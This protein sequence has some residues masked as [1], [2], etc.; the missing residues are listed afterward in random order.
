MN[1]HVFVVLSIFIPASGFERVLNQDETALSVGSSHE[2]VLTDVGSIYVLYCAEESSREHVTTSVMVAARGNCV[3]VRLCHKNVRNIEETLN[4]SFK[5]RT[6]I[7]GYQ[8]LG[9]ATHHNDCSQVKTM[10]L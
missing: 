3:A 5:E 4:Q 6:V 2:K 7:D 9:G 8:L 1:S 10:I